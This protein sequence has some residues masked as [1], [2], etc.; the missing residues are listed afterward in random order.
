MDCFFKSELCG[1]HKRSRQTEG[2]LVNDFNVSCKEYLISFKF[3]HCYE[4]DPGISEKQLIESRCN[5]NFASNHYLC[6]YHRYIYV[7]YW[8][9]QKNYFFPGYQNTTGSN[10][11]LVLQQ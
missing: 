11:H 10:Q 1:I 5:V 2:S 6:A 3:M 7:T 4:K 9:P 8:K